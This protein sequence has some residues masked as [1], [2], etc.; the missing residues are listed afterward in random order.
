MLDDFFIL[1]GRFH[2]LIVHLPIGFIVL[3]ILIELNKKKLGWS[4][5]ALKFIF[6]WASITGAFSIISGFF[7]IKMGISMG[8]CPKPFYCRSFNYNFIFLFYLK[9]IENSIL[10]QYLG[11]CLQLQIRL[12]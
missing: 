5:D 1:I 12:H 11:N 7:N 4:N 8:N 2:P 6:F 10:N 3:G 9:L